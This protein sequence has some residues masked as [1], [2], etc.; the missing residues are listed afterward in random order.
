M[1]QPND[2]IEIYKGEFDL[3]NAN[4]ILH[5]EGGVSFKW[6][7]DSGPYILGRNIDKDR[8][9]LSVLAEQIPTR[10]IGSSAGGWPGAQT[11]QHSIRGK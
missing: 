1:A 10:R 3:K 5:C 7:P 8:E 4:A 11:S 9:S 2:E 6:L